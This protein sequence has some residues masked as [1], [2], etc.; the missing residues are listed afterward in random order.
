MLDVW[1]CAS[2][3]LGQTYPKKLKDEL[4]GDRP[5]SN[6]HG[7]EQEDKNES[8]TGEPGKIHEVELEDFEAE[9]S[10]GVPGKVLL[11]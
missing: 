10:T 1:P 4:A 11:E 7:K 5:V 8:S 9:L 2:S 6:D 3:N